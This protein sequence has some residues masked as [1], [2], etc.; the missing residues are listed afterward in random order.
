MT[1]APPTVTYA[2]LVSDKT[3]RIT[4]TN[5]GLNGLQVMAVDIMNAFVIAPCLEKI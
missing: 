1:E 4:L 2:S 5:A 3:V